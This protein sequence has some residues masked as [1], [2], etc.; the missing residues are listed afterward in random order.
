MKRKKS[1]FQRYKPLLF[2][3][4]VLFLGL[5]LLVSYVQLQRDPPAPSV[6][7]I[8]Q[9]SWGSTE[10][11]IQMAWPS[12][13]AAA[14]GI[15]GAGLVGATRQDRPQPIASLVKVMTA[16]VALK[17]HPLV[18]GDGPLVK[19]EQPDVDLYRSQQ[20]NIESVVPV[21]LG[22]ELSQKSLIQGILIPSGNNLAYMLAN[23]SAGSVDAFVARMNEEAAA[24]G[25]TETKYVDP[26]GI[27]PGNIS[28]A[29]DQLKLAAAAMANPVFAAIVK[30]QQAF[31][32]GAGTVYNVNSELGRQNNIVGVK[33][34]WTEEAGA[35]FMFAADQLVG[36]RS[37]RIYGAV[38]GQDT[39]ADAF[40]S[41]RAI[42][43]SVAPTLEVVT[44]TTKGAPAA[45]ISSKWG[46]TTVASTAQDVSVVL[47]PGYAFETRVERTPALSK[48]DKNTEVGKLIVTAQGQSQEVPLVAQERML[49]AGL[50][51]RLTRLF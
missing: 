21:Q 33:T 32:P 28:T 47:W 42:L 16:Y 46:A 25:M 15:E 11:S 2:I 20:R 7:S 31:I 8:V 29:K 12:K 41:T 27:S 5:F 1:K 30:Q 19:V 26:S 35:C 51:W 37:V 40:G 10:T 14:V 50:K 44:I 4:P 39:L 38:F 49:R 18:Q 6:T 22:M 34:G 48:V 23:W 24:L 3:V 36:D 13:G 45:A 17:D 9:P 43:N